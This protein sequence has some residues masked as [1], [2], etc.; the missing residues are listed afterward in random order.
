MRNIILL[1]LFI[2]TFVNANSLN[3]TKGVKNG[4]EKAQKEHK[5]LMIFVEAKHCP[6]C[7]KMLNTTLSDKDV[8]RNLNKNYILVKVD[9]DSKEGR[10]YFPNI[11][12][13]PTTF[14]STGDKQ[15][16]EEIDGYNNVEFFFWS[17]AKAEKKFKEIK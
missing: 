10:E 2:I 1:I 3:W 11:S 17:M 15:I 16:L 7:H 12:I 4:L 6:W 14:F 9:A 8:V 5:I 13:T